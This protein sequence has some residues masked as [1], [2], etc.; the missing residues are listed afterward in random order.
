M[1]DLMAYAIFFVIELQ[2]FGLGDMAAILAGIEALLGTDATI[3]GV[4]IGCLGASDF[5][6]LAFLMDAARLVVEPAIY[7]RPAGMV[8]APAGIGVGDKSGASQ[9]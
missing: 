1:P 9:C 7:F 8:C 6:L 3:L 4:E 2:L 5:A